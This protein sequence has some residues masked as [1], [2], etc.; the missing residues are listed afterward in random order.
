[1][2][3]SNKASDPAAAALSAI[4]EALNLAGGA[5]PD[6]QKAPT[7]STP[8]FP[9]VSDPDKTPKVTKRS[10]TGMPPPDPALNAPGLPPPPALGGELERKGGERFR[11]PEVDEHPL[12]SPKRPDNAPL[13]DGTP[14]RASPVVPSAPPANDDRHSVGQILRSLNARPSRT[15]MVLATFVSAAWIVLVVLY[16]YANKVTLAT[17]SD[18][19]A[20]P[21]LVLYALLALGPVLFFFVM[22]M[23]ARRAQEMRMTARSMTEVA[24]RLAEPESIATEQM[25]TLSQAVR[26]EVVS[27]GDGIERALARAG[28]L[29][30]MVR[31]EVSNLERSYSENERRIRALVDELSSERDAIFANSE[32]LR[33]VIAGSQ[34]SVFRE[35]ESTAARL[36]DSLGDVGSRVATSLGTK[37]EEIRLA[38]EST[39]DA[40]VEKLASQGGSL[41]TRLGETGDR[42][43]EIVDVNGNGLHEHLADLN[44]RFGALFDERSTMIREG[45][46]GSAQRF[47]ELTDES[48]FKLHAQF[49]QQGNELNERF[50]AT[51]EDTLSTFRARADQLTSELEAH[52]Q[53]TVG[54]FSGLSEDFSARFAETIGE[55]I[56][57]IAMHGDRVNETLAERLLR[58]EDIVSSQ[59]QAIAERLSDET[60]RLNMNLGDKFAAI[61]STL[62]IRG[63]ELDATLGVR[64]QET[65]DALEAQTRAFEER[66]AGKAEEIGHTLDALIQR[67]D[68]GLDGRARTLT[69]TLAARALDIAKILSEGSREV[70]AM[71]DSKAAEINQILGGRATEI[72]D[73]F[74]DRIARF[75]EQIVDR[76]REIDHALGEHA[77][78]IS[79]VLDHETG[80]LAVVLANRAAALRDLLAQASAD[81]DATLAGRA[82]DIGASLA[83]RVNEIGTTLAGRLAELQ[84]A[85]DERRKDLSDTSESIQFGIGST[86]EKL[87]ERTANLQEL[88]GNADANLTARDTTL[89][90]RLH[91]FQST[92]TIVTKDVY[93]LGARAGTT[94]NSANALSD[95]I[96]RQQQ[97]LA[98]AARD[99]ALSQAE[100]DQTLDERRAALESLLESV[101]TRRE[102]FDAVMKTFSGL[103]DESFRQAESRAREIGSFLTE[104]S[105][106]TAGMVDRQFSD[107]RN[108]VGQEREHTGS[109]LRAAYQQANAELEA[110]FGQTTERFQNAATEMRGL[111]HEIKRELEATRG[112]LQRNAVS[113]PQEAS[114]QAAA[115]RRVVADQ[116]KALNELTELVARSGRSYDLSEPAPAP[117]GDSLVRRLDAMRH[118]PPRLVEPQPAAEPSRRE[119]LRP[120]ASV[121]PARPPAPISDRGPSWLSDL[122]ARASREEAP[123]P[124]SIPRP[125]PI[126]RPTASAEPL[127]TISHD[128]ARMVDHAALVDAWDR[129]RRGEPNA[130]T[131]RLYIGRGPQTFEEIRRRYRVDADFRATVDRYVQEFERLLGEVKRDD[132]DDS[133][134]RT[135]LVSETGKVYT[136][137]ANAAGRLG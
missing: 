67:V 107:I 119:P 10:G 8:V 98:V 39:G 87:G 40:L 16:A 11:L 63:A 128:I 109:V 17:A 48:H 83:L 27:M 60:A 23:M 41:I 62:V 125:G 79:S 101:Q 102:D 118:E 120:R 14:E 6:G 33:G 61:E 103:V 22:A 45:F 19:E 57:A 52:A 82:G 9:K 114:E 112:E 47:A 24:M 15:P 105:E 20:R 32:R 86:L 132:R 115:M 29:E 53:R 90:A 93:E 133:L 123:T 127:E 117:R 71:V 77:G 76:L 30:T 106:A 92:L 4:E 73:T 134:T 56:N 43:H 44:Q 100:L 50:A 72:A 97:S 137:L 99:L 28:E 35:L 84:A 85:L 108:A 124:A 59:G 131:N 122:L 65:S 94:I 12:F 36:S 136:M 18:L 74:D 58:F 95:T 69:E 129:Y 80:E 46:E 5:A 37:A 130:F 70:T 38:L 49:E 2:A 113:L 75:E 55:A 21:D 3:T 126:P 1:M 66:T 96:A 25:V 104:A 135:Y 26:R 34:D 110:I 78:N 7:L 121:P 13:R 89:A 88:I 91:E 111:A 54:A 116:I 51:A 68:T 81:L 42:L 64:A 31:T